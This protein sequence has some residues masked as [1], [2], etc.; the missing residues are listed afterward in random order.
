MKRC[1]LPGTDLEVSA[2]CLG[3]M[4]FGTPVGEEE[5]TALVLRA[6]DLGVNFVDTANSYE[7]YARYVGSP[8]GVAEE[9]LGRALRGRRHQVVL[10]TKVGMKVGPTEDDEGLSPAHV[11]RQCDRSLQRLATDRID[12][13]YMH[14]PDPRTPLEE[15][16]AA[17]AGLVGAGK[18]RHWGVSN[19]PADQARTL[20]EVCDRGGWPRPVAHQPALS[21]LR[22]DIEADLLPLCWQE[23]IAVI[24]YRV[25]ES[26]LLTG[27]YRPGHEPPPGSRAADKPDWVPLLRD[28]ALMGRLEELGAEARASGQTLLEYA[29]RQTVRVPGIASLVLGFRRVEQVEEAARALE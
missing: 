11:R 4:T 1:V 24:P 10:A 20:L 27:K 29:L 22:R 9:I 6:L 18:V 26:G 14:R 2:L 5:A 15:S 16:V 7:G 28:A 13:Y 17:F 23:G 21:L 25:L 3:T 8:G 19:F 12:L